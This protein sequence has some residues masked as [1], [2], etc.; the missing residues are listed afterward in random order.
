MNDT[1]SAPGI[2]DTP[3]LSKMPCVSEPRSNATMARSVMSAIDRP[4]V[5]SVVVPGQSLRVANGIELTPRG[6]DLRFVQIPHGAREG[7]GLAGFQDAVDSPARRFI[8]C[9]HRRQV[10][11][12]ADVVRSQEQVR[13][14]RHRLRPQ[15]PGIDQVHQQ[16]LFVGGRPVDVL[17]DVGIEA[18]AQQLLVAGGRP[19]PR[20]SGCASAAP[21]HRLR[22]PRL[23]HSF[24]TLPFS[25]FWS[26]S[27]MSTEMMPFT[28]PSPIE[29][30]CDVTPELRLGDRRQRPWRIDIDRMT[31]GNRDVFC[32]IDL[33]AVHPF[34]DV[35]PARTDAPAP[36]PP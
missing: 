31:V 35:D 25:P 9:F 12:R 10:G 22:S 1:R 8:G 11:V 15:P 2:S 7:G 33:N 20:S 17:P 23:V 6:K 19:G 13:D 27:E 26:H 24:A 14:P 3:R 34:G 30:R 18:P 36:D 29:L 16:R 28:R 21:T 4:I 5:T 32:Q